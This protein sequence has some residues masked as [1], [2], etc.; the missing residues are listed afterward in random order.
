M[1]RNIRDFAWPSALVAMAGLTLALPEPALAQGG[2]G[3]LFKTPSVSIKFETGYGFQRA[4]SEI[5]DFTLDQLTIGRRDFD[6]PYVGGEIAFRAADRW[7]LF[8]NIGH[9]SS[10]VASE[11]RDW[12]DSDDLPIEQVTELR[13]IP[14]TVGAKYYLKERGR[15]VGRFAWIP[16]SVAPFVGGAVG[17]MSYRFEQTG[18][19]ID[20]ETLDVFPDRFESE[21]ET[22]LARALAGVNI[23]LSKQFVFTAEGRYGWASGDLGRDFSGFDRMDLDGLQLVGGLAVRF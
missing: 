23:S 2:D 1:I 22:F 18:D 4:S 17:V 15:A 13:L 6:S 16:T 12:V 20:F 7:D 14:A 11:F 3:F 5:F 8:F 10:S 9:Q 21:G 19:F